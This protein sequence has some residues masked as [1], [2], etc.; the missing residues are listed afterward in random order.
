VFFNE[1]VWH[2]REVLH[3]LFRRLAAQV[4]WDGHKGKENHDALDAA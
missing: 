4:D 2:A 1:G 3:D